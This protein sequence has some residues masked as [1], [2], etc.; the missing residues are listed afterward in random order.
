MAGSKQEK[1]INLSLHLSLFWRKVPW[2]ELVDVYFYNVCNKDLVLICAL[3]ITVG[4]MGH[5]KTVLPM[6]VEGSPTSL[7]SSLQSLQTSYGRNQTIKHG[8]TSPSRLGQQHWQ[9]QH[10][11]PQQMQPPQYLQSPQQSPDFITSGTMPGPTFGP[12]SGPPSR[13]YLGG[14]GTF[15]SPAGI[16]PFQQ[17]QQQ[18]YHSPQQSPDHQPLPSSPIHSGVW[19]HKAGHI[20]SSS[21]SSEG[22]L[23]SPQRDL[24]DNY[25]PNG[26]SDGSFPGGPGFPMTSGIGQPPYGAPSQVFSTVDGSPIWPAHAILVPQGQIFAN[27]L[28]TGE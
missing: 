12:N 2:I 10:Q 6:N 20:G 23:P 21:S 22:L 25:I 9:Q 15:N 24:R 5:G 3:D 1:D 28:F 18:Q 11:Y 14:E 26:N 13:K 4:R 16:R 27:G 19:G 17:R 8:Q 7:Q